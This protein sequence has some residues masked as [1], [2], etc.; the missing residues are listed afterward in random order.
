[1]PKHSHEGVEATMVF[2]GGYS[3]E[4][5]D[6]NKGD[7]LFLMIMKNILQYHQNKLVVYV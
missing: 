5:G 3:D 1:M 2:H 6:Y 7:L 4:V